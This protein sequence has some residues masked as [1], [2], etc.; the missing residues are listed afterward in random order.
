M[1]RL[2]DKLETAMKA[3]TQGRALRFSR[4]NVAGRNGY[5]WQSVQTDDAGIMQA[6]CDMWNHRATI[7]QALREKGL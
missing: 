3:G 4:C 6:L 5:R 2:S 1:T 7:I